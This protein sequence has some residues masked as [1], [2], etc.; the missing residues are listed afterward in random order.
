MVDHEGVGPALGDK[1][2]VWT[3]AD[4]NAFTGGCHYSEG[5][6]G[7]K[8]E[9]RDCPLLGGVNDGGLA[10]AGWKRKKAAYAQ[11][12]R[13]HIICPS[14]WMAERVR[15][16]S[17]L[18]DKPVHYIP[19]A[20][21]TQRFTPTHKFVARLRLGLPPDRSLLLFGADSLGN[22]RKGGEQLRMAIERLKAMGASDNVELVLFGHQTIELPIRSHAMGHVSDDV[23]LALIYAAAD[24]FIFPSHEDNAPLT[25]GEAMLCGTP[26]VAFP[27]GNVPDL[28][29]HGDTGYI[30]RHLDVDDLVAGIRWV[31]DTEP[32][33]KILRS[34]RC[35]TTAEA[36]HD[37]DTAA[38][39][40][41]RIYEEVIRHGP[42]T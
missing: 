24:A 7:Y 2:I 17:L 15:E 22:K 25:V 19:N 20:F 13:L 26:V 6:D 35:R 32:S 31:L 3:L 38:V 37:P 10:H 18:G 11:L 1:P 28:I 36:I 14:K 23:Q 9:C 30:A 42:V 5:C 41:D 34:I 16:S 12:K 4:M 29:R 21:P 40:H 27:V 8:R 33:A 39:R